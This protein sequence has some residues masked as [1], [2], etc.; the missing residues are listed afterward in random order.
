VYYEVGA[1]AVKGSVPHTALVLEAADGSEYLLVGP[2]SEQ[3][4]RQHQG[5]T[6]RLR[7]RIVR[8][9]PAPGLPPQL[10]VIRI[11]AVLEP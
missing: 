9:S 2:L 10:E 3:I 1:V 8:D 5:R 4:G 7:G 6:I 11:L